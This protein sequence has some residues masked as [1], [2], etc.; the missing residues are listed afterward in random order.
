MERSEGRKKTARNELELRDTSFEQQHTAPDGTTEQQ[1]T[2]FTEWS[3]RVC[4][5]SLQEPRPTSCCGEHAC[6]SCAPE[7]QPCPLCSE[8][9]AASKREDVLDDSWVIVELPTEVELPATTT[10]S[11]RRTRKRRSPPAIEPVAKRLRS[12]ARRKDPSFSIRKELMKSKVTSPRLYTASG[13]LMEIQFALKG[14][15]IDVSVFARPGKDD[16]DLSWPLRGKVQI[17]LIDIGGDTH[18]TSEIPGTWKN[19]G[20]YCKGQLDFPYEELKGDRDGMIKFS[21]RVISRSHTP[22][23]NIIQIFYSAACTLTFYFLCL[24]VHV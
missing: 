17:F 19:P 1:E 4:S 14:K 12:A 8:R 18:H 10:V 23:S 21:V 24:D 9:G 11:G 7:D 2:S 3:C 13:Y 20:T 15:N 5:K 22:P 16:K 6:Q